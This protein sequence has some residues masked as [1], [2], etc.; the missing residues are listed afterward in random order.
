MMDP[1]AYCS[2]ALAALVLLASAGM[3]VPV[4]LSVVLIGAGVLAAHGTMNVA[5]IILLVAGSA[6]LGDTLGYACGRLGL[7]WF[8]RYGATL[9]VGPGRPAHWIRTVVTRVL[10]VGVVRR[11]TGWTAAWLARG[12]GMGGLILLSR[13]VLGVFG[14]VINILS[15]IQR[16]PFGRFLLYDAVG[17]T[18]WAGTYIGLGFVTGTRV[19]NAASLVTN[20]VMIVLMLALTVGPLLLVA[21]TTPPGVAPARPSLTLSTLEH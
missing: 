14:P 2:V 8:R 16:Y 3:P 13:T 10:M 20:P 11:A 7:A 9:G 15:G 1:R 12:G 6:I 4:P 21:R 19:H 18:I 17:E 5:S